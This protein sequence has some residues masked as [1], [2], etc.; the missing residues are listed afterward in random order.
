M[1]SS[2]RDPL[3]AFQDALPVDDDLLRIL[4]LP[5][6]HALLMAFASERRK[7]PDSDLIDLS[8]R[9]KRGGI[10]GLKEEIRALLRVDGTRL[11]MRRAALLW[12]LS[13]TC[14]AAAMTKQGLPAQGAHVDLVRMIGELVVDLTLRGTDCDPF[15]VDVVLRAKQYLCWGREPWAPEENHKEWLRR[16]LGE[17]FDFFQLSKKVPYAA[18]TLP[19]DLRRNG[20]SMILEVSEKDGS[21]KLDGMRLMSFDRGSVGRPL[22]M[23]K[24]PNR[25]AIA[26]VELAQGGTPELTK[27]DARKLDTWILKSGVGNVVVRSDG[28]ERKRGRVTLITKRDDRPVTIHLS[29]IDIPPQLPSL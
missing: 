11:R 17:Q 24:R 2:K 29:E 27:V 26:L 10:E 13:L 3:R 23:G 16:A 14:G 15:E 5:A 12:T 1:S 25:L 28:T 8:T 20:V 9:V 7:D 6:F 4:L 19:R 22:R 21:L 18:P